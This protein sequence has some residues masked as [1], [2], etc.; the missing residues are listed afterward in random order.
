M[1]LPLDDASLPTDEAG[2]RAE[3]A[4]LDRHL[5]ENQARVRELMD[6]EDPDRG[7]FNAAAI[8]E[9]KQMGM[10]LRY[11]KELRQARIRRSGLLGMH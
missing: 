3:I 7:I 6:Q 11:Q 4:E 8:H 5:A 2:L 10:M 9:A 1:T